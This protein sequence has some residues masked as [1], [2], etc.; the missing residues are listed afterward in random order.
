MTAT[1]TAPANAWSGL[2]LH[3]RSVDDIPTSWP[4]AAVT[5]GVFDG[6]HRGHATL[7]D[8]CRRHADR[9]GLPSALLTF[10]PHPMTVTC[11]ERAPRML[12]SVDER[13][14][15]AHRLGIDAVLVLHFDRALAATAPAD[16][17]EDVLVGSLGAHAVVVGENF[18]YGARGQGDPAHLRLM[19]SRHGFTVDTVDLVDHHGTVC[20]STEIRRAL[21]EG[22]HRRAEQLIGRPLD[23]QA[24]GSQSL[25]GHSV[26]RSHPMSANGRS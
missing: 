2:R 25:G 23:S 18:R 24:A 3:W 7:V 11:P 8:R 5:A 9:L 13:V 17:V 1:A 10:D 16:F 12:A 6:F 15:A 22:D 20:S 26:G 14:E 19:G 21:A 4:G